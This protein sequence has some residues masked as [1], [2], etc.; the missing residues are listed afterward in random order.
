[1][2]FLYLSVRYAAMPYI[3]IFMLITL[4]TISVADA[5]RV[6]DILNQFAY[7]NDC[8]R[9][10]SGNIL[11]LALNWLNVVVTALLGVIM[12]ARLHAMYQQSRNILVFLVVMFLGIT[13]ACV[14]ITATATSHIIG[15]EFI[16]SGTCQCNYNYEGDAQ[17]LN[18]MTWIL[19]TLWEVLSLCLAVWIAVKR[20][21][22]LRRRPR[23]E[24]TFG[25]CLMVVI[26]T[27]VVY[28]A[29]FAVGSCFALGFL[30]PTLTLFFVSCAA[31]IYDWALAFG[32]EFELVWVSRVPYLNN[33]IQ[34]KPGA[35]ETLD[36]RNSSISRC[37]L[38]WNIVHRHFHA[39]KSSNSLG[40]RFRVSK[41]SDLL[42]Q[43]ND[44]DS[45]N[46]MYSAL[47]WMTVVVNAMLGVVIITRLHV[48]YQQ[49]RKMLVFLVSIF[50]AVTIAC[51]VIAVIGS[52]NTLGEQLILSGTYQC[53]Y[54]YEGDT[55][56]L[57]SMAWLLYTVWEVLALCLAVWIVIKHFRALRRP[58]AG[59]SIGDCFTVL[60]KAHV[61][62]FASFVAVSCFQLGFLS[63]GILDSSSVGADV[64]AG[65]LE[66]A[67]I[68]QMFVLGPRLILSIREY[69]AKLV[70]DSDTGI[71]MPPMVFQEGSDVSSGD[72][73]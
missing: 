13:I 41:I 9:W 20:F 70:A 47:T 31:V 29:S 26:K 42:V 50:L 39:A 56:L 55:G 60:I 68:A 58:L 6:S 71:D 7:Y 2:T 10:L 64:Y 48:M 22:E 37:A 5:V 61:V 35:A 18:S 3:V 65:L 53:T 73:V 49:S 28:F 44:I 45:C 4:P 27:H 38:P 14:G 57:D 8:N 43:Y 25:D 51:G 63:P 1:M 11:F 54:D 21:R 15:E 72:D 36:P 30:S 24:W 34:P 12:I 16:L 46:I 52:K 33:N 69:D 32:Q 40:D 17:L 62:Y 59:W 66:F 19:C 23:G 67:S